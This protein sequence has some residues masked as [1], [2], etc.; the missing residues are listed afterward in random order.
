MYTTV[1]D[2]VEEKVVNRP[3]TT[4]GIYSDEMNLQSAAV[5]LAKYPGSSHKLYDALTERKLNYMDEVADIKARRA[6]AQR[7]Q[8]NA[9]P[10]AEVELKEFKGTGGKSRRTR[11]KCRNPRK[12]SR[13]ARR[14]SRH[15]RK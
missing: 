8:A 13:C 7:A 6:Q 3:W 4:E 11:R 10:G 14:K 5:Q 2:G 12:K 9:R 15:A 1:I